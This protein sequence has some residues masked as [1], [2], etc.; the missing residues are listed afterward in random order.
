MPEQIPPHVDIQ[1]NLDKAQ[2]RPRQ[3]LI[4]V[5]SVVLTLALS[6]VIFWLSHNITLTLVLLP[7][8]IGIALIVYGNAQEEHQELLIA[9]GACAIFSSLLALIIFGLTLEPQITAKLRDI[10]IIALAAMLLVIALAMVVLI[11]QLAMLTV[12]LRDEIKP[13]VESANDTV[14]ALRGTATFM[15]AHVVEPTIKVSSTVAGVQR[16]L[17]VLLDLRPGKSRHNK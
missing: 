7:L 3:I 16:I 4:I 17:Q 12:L 6:A 2:D 5:A 11:Y 15:S 9:T 14:N 1:P 13:L 8:W 10:A